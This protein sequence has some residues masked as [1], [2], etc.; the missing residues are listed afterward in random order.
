MGGARPQAGSPP[1]FPGSFRAWNWL[2]IA[3]WLTYLPGLKKIF[4]KS[5]LFGERHRPAAGWWKL[6]GLG[7]SPFMTDGIR[8]LSNI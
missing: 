7:W 1:L 5:R 4:G 3:V 2:D 8:A 6:R